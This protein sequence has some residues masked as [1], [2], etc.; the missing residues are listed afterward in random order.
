MSGL[1]R[2]TLIECPRSQSDEGI[3][4]NNQNPSQWT[5]RVG[6]GL[7]LKAGDKISVHSSYISEIGA[8]AGAIQIKGQDLN[9]SV[10]V[11]ITEFTNTMESPEVPVK[12]IHQ[13]AENVKKTI[14]IRDD[15]LNL[16]VSPYKCTNGE[17]YCHLPRRFTSVGT[18]NHWDR[19]HSRDV[20]PVDG[21]L[22]QTV[23]PPPPLNR[24]KSDI[25]TKYWAYRTGV[26]HGRHRI[27][28]INDGSRFTL[29]TRKETFYD[30]PYS[31]EITVTGQ[32]IDNTGTIKLFHG[33]T[34]KELFK[35][36]ELITQSPTTAF[37]VGEVINASITSDDTIEM[38]GVASTTTN[39]FNKFTFRYPLAD[40]DFKLPPTTA[41]SGATPD[42]AESF[43]DPA[44]WGDYIQVKN[45]ISIK[46]NPGYNSPTDLADQLTQELNN[47]TD[48]ET[49]AYP[50]E[51]TTPSF[52]RDEKFTF[53]TETPCN[54][55]YNCATPTNFQRDNFNSWFN[56]GGTWNV[57]NAY[58]YLSN[59]KHI[60]IKRPELY[61]TGLE[62]NGPF[63]DPPGATS[64]VE[65]VEGERNGYNI[66]QQTP[67]AKDDQ[68]FLTG[69]KWNK[70]NILRFKDFFDAQKTYPEL[71]DYQ[72][73]GYD[74]DV[75][76]T[77]FIHCNLFD[78][79]NG[80]LEVFALNDAVRNWN[81]GTNIRDERCPNLGYDLY[82]SAVSSSQTSFPM[83]IDYNPNTENLT[84]NDVGYTD[85]GK[86][87]FNPNLE[88][89]YD[90]LAYG[91]ARKYRVT[92]FAEV[93]DRGAEF[94]IGF[95]FTRTG[96]K[97]P[98]HFF[99]TNASAHAG[100]PTETL[101]QGFRTFGFDWHFTA[102]G[103]AAIALY[104]GNMNER[105]DTFHTATL[106]NQVKQYRF[107]QA[108]GGKIYNL[109]PYQWGMYLGA[110]TPQIVYDTDQQRFQLRNLHTAETVGNLKAAGFIEAGGSQVP[111]N[112]NA[113][114]SC[115]KINKR[116]LRWNFSP[117]MTP[118]ADNF[119]A[120]FTNGSDN[121][122]ISHNVAIEPWSIM[123]AQSGL[124]IEDW[125]VP[126]NLWDESLVGTMGYRYNQFHN[127][128]T[129]SSRQVRLKAHG[130]N[131]DLDNVNILTTNANIGEADVKGYTQN[132]T[133]APQYTPVLPVGIEPSG[134]NFDIPGRYITPAITNS[135]ANSVNI[136]AERLPT[137][138]LRPYY[139]IRSDIIQEPNHVLGGLTSGVTMPIV[140]ITN[141]A[142]PYGDFINGFGGAI[143]FT[144]TI[145]R[146]ITKIQ[147][148][149]HEP[150]GSAARCDLNSAVIFRIDQ[151][152]PA[153]LDIVDNLLQSKKKSDQILA[154]EI[155]DPE[156]QFENVKYK[157]KE[158][159]Q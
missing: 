38:S 64:Y 71:F 140:A 76:E 73:S 25:N 148:S 154:E 106:I 62:V 11:E 156:L 85:R 27:D 143:T 2:T 51:A 81:Y 55:V 24:C 83:F 61:T 75:N 84:E 50:T 66:D 133:A 120:S 129:Q 153:Q 124:F 105:G 40:S 136:T 132:T 104:N 101:G 41:N 65:G 89:D 23:L 21:D 128:N 113:G 100:D 115:Y 126:E 5:N 80:S 77:R 78:V 12:F 131:A 137:K 35:G 44:L 86:T 145:D 20:N 98:D 127:P 146:V 117:D 107:S 93:E 10:E 142:N 9:A 1:T 60:G 32:A 88:A 42:Q 103:T 4:N 39:T 97:I 112:A 91:F 152:V 3:A 26:A 157:S 141:K 13:K 114:D 15:T 159:F 67:M 150:D 123:D 29:F 59:F 68:L 108:T 48:I 45:L 90:D 149:I 49:F 36:M 110:D 34:T 8:E 95:Q 109:D 74:C 17:Y 125:V 14:N 138:T 52:V 144:N 37:G 151:Q 121:A 79:F 82:N 102:Y 28:G 87:Y 70:E 119:S 147:C 158:L 135:P 53:K 57:P 94:Y 31:V 99:H 63:A 46:A 69:I 111:V 58:K 30:S 56:T 16:I 130:A 22:G 7:H 72:Q 54:Q 33:S 155:E 134:T 96:G 43:R 116:M 118:Y 6:S 18:D 122:Y 19:L 139:T 47:R 92:T